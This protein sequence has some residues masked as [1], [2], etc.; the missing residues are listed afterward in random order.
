M[1]KFKLDAPKSLGVVEEIMPLV[2]QLLLLPN[3]V[4]AIYKLHCTMGE[5][6]TKNGR[7]I[8]NQRVKFDIDIEKLTPAKQAVIKAV[9]DLVGTEY[10]E[11][12]GYGSLTIT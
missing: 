8:A 7:F 1:S 3:E 10:A 11:F 9:Q 2:I 4:D 5:G 12:K 6:E